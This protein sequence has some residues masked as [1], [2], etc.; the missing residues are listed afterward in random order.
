MVALVTCWRRVLVDSQIKFVVVLSRL[1]HRRVHIPSMMT[2][3]TLL[4]SCNSTDSVDDFFDGCSGVWFVAIA[5]QFSTCW[6]CCIKVLRWLESV[7]CALDESAYRQRGELVTRRRITTDETFLELD[8]FKHL[9]RF[10]RNEIARLSELLLPASEL[11]RCQNG[12]VAHRIEA[13]MLL[14]LTFTRPRTQV[15]CEA[16]ERM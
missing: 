11:I 2:M 6:R 4:G 7:G 12:T 14:L 10:P 1:I 16:C 15:R 5:S 9:F 13:M 3:L 8:V